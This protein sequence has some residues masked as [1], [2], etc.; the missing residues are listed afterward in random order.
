LVAHG[1]AAAA[2]KQLRAQLHAGASHLVVHAVPSTDRLPIVAA[3]APEL[4][5]AAR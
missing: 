3:L 4:G 5:I 2:A 1:D